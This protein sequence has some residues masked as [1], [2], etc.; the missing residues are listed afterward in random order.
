MI[1][2]D[3]RDS[4]CSP[5]LQISFSFCS[6]L[7]W[8]LYMLLRSQFAFTAVSSRWGLL[9]SVLLCIS[10]LLFRPPLAP[11]WS[12]SS[13]LL[14]TG[15]KC[16]YHVSVITLLRSLLRKKTGEDSECVCGKITMHHKPINL[17]GKSQGQREETGR[18][19]RRDGRRA[20]RGEWRYANMDDGWLTA[21]REGRKSKDQE[22]TERMSEGTD[23]EMQT[24]WERKHKCKPPGINSLIALW[25]RMEKRGFPPS[26]PLS[27]PLI[28]LSFCFIF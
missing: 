3:A 2:K 15:I 23:T 7:L 19:K 22:G 8:P 17:A 26:Y 14:H 12:H 10:L 13:V 28:S 4:F 5:H 21:E 11:Y 24:D 27:L 20:K 25:G 1:D 9:Y 6:A 16:K 18:R